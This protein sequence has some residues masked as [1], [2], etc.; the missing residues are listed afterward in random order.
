MKSA[1]VR[2]DKELKDYQG[3]GSSY[4]LQS[5]YTEEYVGGK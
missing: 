3:A 1:T 4:R 2:I 5:R